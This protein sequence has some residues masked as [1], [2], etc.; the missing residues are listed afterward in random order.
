MMQLVEFLNLKKG[1][2]VFHEEFGLLTISGKQ[3]DHIFHAKTLDGET[4]L[5]V[6][7]H[8]LHKSL[9]SSS[10]I[11]HE[12]YIL[13]GMNETI[14]SNELLTTSSIYLPDY[15]S[16]GFKIAFVLKPK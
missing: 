5:L 6:S 1:N 12:L 10:H 13:K 14:F 3:K 4:V 11:G 8:N 9:I 2:K 7:P 16:M 15:L